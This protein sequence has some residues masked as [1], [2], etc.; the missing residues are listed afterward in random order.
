MVAQVYDVRSPPP[1]VSRSDASSPL[2]PPR[3]KFDS[4]MLK[5]YIKKLL[6]TTLQSAS[7]PPLRERERTKSWCKE[8]GERVKERMLGT[9]SPFLSCWQL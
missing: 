9:Y 5:T 7:W 4:E 8:I 6:A 3:S 1:T 2:V